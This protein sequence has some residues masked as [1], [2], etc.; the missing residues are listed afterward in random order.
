MVVTT[1]ECKS[2]CLHPGFL[3]LPPVLSVYPAH[4]QAPSCD[5][6]SSYS[7][8][9]ATQAPQQPRIPRSAQ[10]T[11]QT[12]RL[13]PPSVGLPVAYAT[14][15]FSHAYFSLAVSNN[16]WTLGAWPFSNTRTVALS[17]VC[18][19]YSASGLKT[20]LES[21]SPQSRPE[22]TLPVEGGNCQLGG[23]MIGEWKPR[24]REKMV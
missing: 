21:V 3:L 19:L 22:P 9:P 10:L 12:S 23:L 24:G 20:P 4:L 8:S 1:F 6:V 15:L 17:S 18:R 5:T 13:T 16:T 14:A 2:F 11:C 7:E